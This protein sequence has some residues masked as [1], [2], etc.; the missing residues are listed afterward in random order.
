MNL[1][2]PK[3]TKEYFKND[4]NRVLKISNLGLLLNKYVSAWSHDWTT[5]EKRGKEKVNLKT[6]FLCMIKKEQFYINQSKNILDSIY[7]RQLSI[8]QKLSSSS[9]HVET[10]EAITDS[11]LIVGLGST[12]VIETG[13]T[14]HPLY[15]FPYLP[16]SGLKGLARAYA[17][18][19]VE[20][21][22]NGKEI[23]EIFGSDDKDPKKAILDNYQGKVF[24]MDG[25]PVTFPK[26]E[27]DIM[28]PHY[29]AYYKGEKPPADYLNPVP[30]TF[31]A[32]AAGEK[33]FFALYSRDKALAEKA[34]AWLI[35]GLTELGAG[36][37]TNVGYGYFRVE[38]SKAVTLNSGQTMQPS[39][40]S[41]ETIIWENAALTW[42][43]GNQ[44]LKAEKDNK[45]AE[46]KI[47]DKSFVPETMHKQ[48]FDKKKS[49]TAK[50]TVEK[51][52]NAYK[53]LRIEST[54]S[55]S[56]GR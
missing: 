28:N 3:E 38:E 27:L 43:P 24:F 40:I 33:F 19:A 15:G 54:S 32:V 25:L 56:A 44:T 17:E 49:V 34:K 20:P 55:P 8:I 9:W 7:K 30:V 22:P 35:G 39:A 45:K 4:K 16:G 21:K 31:L 37:K 36:G 6:E 12:S 46:L 14:L 47:S 5:E 11:R 13:M 2:L 18:M 1:P 53:I 41:S 51:T 48:L 10:F 42:N 23:H 29:D 26:L 50:V 52:G